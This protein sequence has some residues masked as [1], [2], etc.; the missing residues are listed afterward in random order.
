[1]IDPG[2]LKTRR[3]DRSGAMRTL[4]EN[5]DGLAVLNTNDL[6]KGLNRL[7]D[8]M[9]SYY[10][11]GYYASNTKPDG[12]FREITVRSSSQASRC[13]RGRGIARRRPGSSPRPGG[14][15]R[16]RQ[17]PR[18]QR[19]CRRPSISWQA[20]VPGRDFASMPSSGR[21]LA[22]D[23]GGGRAASEG[24]V[25]TSSGRAPRR[26]SRPPQASTTATAT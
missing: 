3:A 20:F 19:R 18:Q 15:S 8:D 7:A 22:L 13:G 11:L 14:Q 2:G 26:P 6:D 10:L 24:S 9:S 25:R 12:R 1:M 16:V 5:T 23:V 4:A 21:A 17:C